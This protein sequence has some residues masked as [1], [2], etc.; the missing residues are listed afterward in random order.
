[1]NPTD[2]QARM[3]MERHSQ[4]ALANMLATAD[5]TLQRVAAIG[6]LE[7]CD[8]K[9]LA[10]EARGALRLIHGGEQ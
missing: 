3:F 7:G 2:I 5:R 10:E 8:T 1:M 9:A 6:R 4:A